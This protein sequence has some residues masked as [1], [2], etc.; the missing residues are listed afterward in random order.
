MQLLSPAFTT[1]LR[2]VRYMISFNR[3]HNR[4]KINANGVHH[5]EG[6]SCK[7]GRK[8]LTKTVY[9]DGTREDYTK[10]PVRH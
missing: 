4:V 1:L 8:G 2:K 5:I 6:V 3:Y 9:V 10:E 7:C